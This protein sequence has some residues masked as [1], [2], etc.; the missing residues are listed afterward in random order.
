LLLLLTVEHAAQRLVALLVILYTKS[1]M[2][3]LLVAFTSAREE[4]IV[5]KCVF[6]SSKKLKKKQKLS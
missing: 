6:I 5:S 4:M 2:S 3:N 1:C